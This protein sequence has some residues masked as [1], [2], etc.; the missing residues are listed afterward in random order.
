MP[1]SAR[2][3]L[4]YSKPDSPKYAAGCVWRTA[5]GCQLGAICVSRYRRRDDNFIQIV[6]TQIHEYSGRQTK[7]K[8][9][10][11]C[12]DARCGF[13]PFIAYIGIQR[14]YPKHNHSQ[15]HAVDSIRVG[16]NLGHYIYMRR[17]RLCGMWNVFSFA[18]IF[19][20]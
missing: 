3:P 6:Q 5:A 12:G 14:I 11:R 10:L 7:C 16:N 18:G 8:W 4:L 20:R 13:K 2:G 9:V 17:A 15:S 1:T 19:N